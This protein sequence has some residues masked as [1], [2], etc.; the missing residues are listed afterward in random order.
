MK[1]FIARRVLNIAAVSAVIA[2]IALL[3]W[4]NLF[5][6]PA[7]AARTIIIVVW[8]FFGV[9]ALA[10]LVRAVLGLRKRRRARTRGP[11][12]SAGEAAQ[13]LYLGR[14]STPAPEREPD[15]YSVHGSPP[16]GDRDRDDR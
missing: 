13:D 6:P 10:A 12:A 9:I 14:V 5:G 1:S 4:L 8:C 16:P 11:L 3:V 2:G 15:E 7:V